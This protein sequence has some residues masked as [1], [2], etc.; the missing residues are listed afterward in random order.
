MTI[1]D[2]P[3]VFLPHEPR[4]DEPTG[5]LEESAAG[6][7]NFRNAASIANKTR[8]SLEATLGSS[9]AQTTEQ[10]EDAITHSDVTQ[11]VK[12]AR[13]H[14]R[15]VQEILDRGRR[16][17]QGEKVEP[18]VQFSTLSADD[19]AKALAGSSKPKETQPTQSSKSKSGEKT[20]KSFFTKA[21]ELMS[22]IEEKNKIPDDESD[23]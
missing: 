20:G 21:I 9:E 15:E 13:E 7:K 5:P 3:S 23:K 4:N 2:N 11:S 1:K 19:A 12:A 6:A 14:A 8:D 17:A 22:G 10:L 18:T 16:R